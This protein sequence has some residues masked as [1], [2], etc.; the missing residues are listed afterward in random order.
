MGK[1]H[2]KIKAV[3]SR[4]GEKRFERV[5][6]F[7]IIKEKSDNK[8]YANENVDYVYSACEKYD[9]GYTQLI[10]II[11]THNMRCCF[12]TNVHNSCLCRFVG[13]KQE[14]L[15]RMLYNKFR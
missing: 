13:K 5:L 1:G 2:L 9:Y 7:C 6:Q 8:Y 11:I 10:T 12:V 15:E 3:K 4:P 14:M